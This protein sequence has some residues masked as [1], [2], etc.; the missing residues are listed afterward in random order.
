MVKKILLSLCAV[1][2]LAGCSLPGSQQS[3]DEEM[4]TRV[5]EILASSVPPATATQLVFPTN[6]PTQP[7]IVEQ[8]LPPT[9]TPEATATIE[10][11]AAPTET[12]E[13]T[14]TLEV[15]TTGVPAVE[16]T[17][18]VSVTT[19][20]TPTISTDDPKTLFGKP[21]DTDTMDNSEKWFWSTGSDSFTNTAWSNGAMV[22]TGL[23]N[24]S[25][26]RIPQTKYASNMYIDMTVKSGSCSG[27][28]NYGFIFR[29]P[30][31]NIPEQGYLFSVSCDGQ[32][33]LWEWNG[34]A[35]DKGVATTLI[36]WKASS[37]INAGANKTNRLGV[38]ANGKTIRL[39]INGIFLE[40]VLDS[41]YENGGFGVY[42]DAG[43]TSKYTIEVDEISYWLDPK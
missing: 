19:G 15:D 23:T 4:A 38:W 37:N 28:D 39:Y 25:G 41:T 20:P 2:L 9:S 3:K 29:V 33:R 42:V 21:T 36:N 12:L 43:P 11:T 35:G 26:W 5:A 6:E 32:Y 7:V 16:V 30:V 14:A 24:I 10:V 1:L 18:L 22:L 27:N 8:T 40:E 34:K 31:P 17:P 13:P